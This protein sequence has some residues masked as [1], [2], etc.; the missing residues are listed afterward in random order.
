M[1]IT[2]ITRLAHSSVFKLKKNSPQILFVA[3]IVGTIATTVL[4]SRATLKA[5]H[6]I[7]DMT[8]EREAID[9]TSMKGGYA[10]EEY[11]GVVVEQYTLGAVQLTKLYGPTVIVGVVS[12]ACL[13]KSHRQLTNRNTALTVAYT[14]LYKTFQNYRA[15]VTDQLGPEIDQQFLHGTVTEEIETT[16]KNGK[17]K[18]KEITTLDSSSEAEL[19]RWFSRET[20]TSWT[21][22]P[23]YNQI[24]LDGQEK[25]ATTLLH[26]QGHLFLNEVYDL[27][28]FQR[29]K[30]GSIVGWI[31]KDLG[32]NDSFVSFNHHADGEFLA[33]Y[34]KDVMLEFNVMGPILDLI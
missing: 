8:E 29:T 23:G 17:K 20:S 33:G 6:V 15:R 3:G 32:N 26:R 4:A 22:D 13:T 25:W 11:T 18:V 24:M 1:N 19:T 14:G 2:P 30:T 27:L 9:I 21:Q 16:D 34:S 31:H 5:Q 12:I 28:G 7:V 10:P